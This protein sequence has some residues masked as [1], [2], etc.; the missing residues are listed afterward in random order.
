MGKSEESRVLSVE[1]RVEWWVLNAHKEQIPG[2]LN[3]ADGG[4]STGD[5]LYGFQKFS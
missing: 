1:C 4:G 2:H 3:K 5:K